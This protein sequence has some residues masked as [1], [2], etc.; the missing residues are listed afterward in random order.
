MVRPST[1]SWRNASPLII[2]LLALVLAG[3][4]ATDARA[5]QSG[6][7]S[8]LLAHEAPTARSG[9]EKAHAQAER[10]QPDSALRKIS[11]SAA[12]TSGAAMEDE[13]WT[14]IFYSK[15][16]RRSYEI[17]VFGT[18]TMGSEGTD[19]QAV[20]ELEDLP[21][22]FTDSSKAIELAR[23]GGLQPRS[24]IRMMLTKPAEE[25]ATWE[26]SS[27]N[28]GTLYLVDAEAGKFLRVKE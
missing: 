26:V 20:A 24:Q 27:G 15:R 25:P 3:P 4:G 1:G 5:E 7:R 22:E 8:S 13:G 6:A 28:P 21:D 10:W 23:T 9:L 19:A 2:S 16:L 14:Y 17:S 18:M 12:T 11:I